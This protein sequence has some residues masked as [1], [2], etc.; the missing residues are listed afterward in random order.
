MNERQTIPERVEHIKLALEIISGNASLLEH[1]IAD[2]K[3]KT[4][5]LMLNLEYRHKQ[6]KKE[7]IKQVIVKLNSMLDNKSLP[8]EAKE[9]ISR[10]IK[11]AENLVNI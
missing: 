2:L 6:G 4:N 7:E 10:L 9:I 1:G 8:E 5:L 11:K 3:E